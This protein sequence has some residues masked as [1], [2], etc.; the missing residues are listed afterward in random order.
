MVNTSEILENDYNNQLDHD[1]ICPK[2]GGAHD[3][4]SIGNTERIDQST[5]AVLYE[6]LNCGITEFQYY[7]DIIVLE[8]SEL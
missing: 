4:E 6:C 2:F 7:E 8:D 1:D 5:V 3:F